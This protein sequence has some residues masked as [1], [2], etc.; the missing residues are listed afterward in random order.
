[1]KKILI[2]GLFFSLLI[3]S[4]CSLKGANK[5]KDANQNQTLP[6]VVSNEAR[7]VARDAFSIEAPENWKESPA[8]MPGISLMMV[9]STE[10]SA[11][12]EVKR[13]NFK[14]YFSI[15]YATLDE[16]NLEEYTAGLKKQL[17]NMVGDIEFQDL[18]P[19]VID[20]R[21]A[22]VFSADL[23]QQGLDFKFLMFVAAGKNKDVWMISFN[24]LA[25]DL[26]GYRDLFYKI[27]TSFK[28]K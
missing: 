17:V 25:D 19:T 28:E 26:E 15:S 1:M 6:P 2:Y 23:N 13:I 16:K 18:E 4:G 9:N 11:R 10:A 22:R 7:L 8:L 27:A 14:S 5:I 12:P 3:F 24:T 20:G 21:T